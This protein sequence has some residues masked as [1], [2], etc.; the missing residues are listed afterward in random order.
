M[1]LSYYPGAAVPSAAAAAG[2]AIDALFHAS[3]MAVA[4]A[5]GRRSAPN[6][7]QLIDQFRCT[8]LSYTVLQCMIVQYIPTTPCPR[9]PRV[10]GEDGCLAIGVNRQRQRGCVTSPLSL[11]LRVVLARA[12]GRA[13]RSSFFT[14]V[15]ERRTKF[16]V[17]VSTAP[18]HVETVTANG[19]KTAERVPNDPRERF[20]I[21][22]DLLK[23]CQ[24]FHKSFHKLP[25]SCH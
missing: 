16:V 21:L 23:K 1:C 13:D 8:V 19:Q 6:D 14:L 11:T 3:L 18:F 2:A 25:S 5:H 20:R 22:Q 24:K 9:L 15:S 10:P 17:P 12:R 4:A 7:D